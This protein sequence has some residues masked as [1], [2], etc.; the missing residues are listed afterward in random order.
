MSLHAAQYK[1][2][3]LTYGITIE[4]TYQEAMMHCWRTGIEYLGV[5]HQQIPVKSE[6]RISGNEQHKED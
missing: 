6:L 5:I 4:G 3:N 2:G 1:V